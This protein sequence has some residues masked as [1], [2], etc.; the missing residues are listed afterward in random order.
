LAISQS[1][2]EPIHLMFPPDRSRALRTAERPAP[3]GTG[4]R[5]SRCGYLWFVTVREVLTTVVP[6]TTGL[7]IDVFVD[8]EPGI[9]PT[10]VYV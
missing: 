3:L 10:S 2:C 5:C 6:G 1:T 9:N 4:R 8:V 7:T